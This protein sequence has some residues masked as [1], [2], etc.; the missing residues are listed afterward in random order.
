[1]S[2]QPDIIWLNTSPSLFCLA[3]PL[4]SELSHHTTIVQWKY[5][6]NQDEASSLDIAILLLDNYLQSSHQPVHLIGHI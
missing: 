5:T 3:Q 2:R 1:M 6:Q 4:L